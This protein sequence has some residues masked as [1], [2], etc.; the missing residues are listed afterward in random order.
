MPNL[1]RRRIASLPMLIVAVSM[2]VLIIVVATTR[3]ALQRPERR[4][5]LNRVHESMVNEVNIRKLPPFPSSATVP[6]PSPSSRKPSLSP[7]PLAPPSMHNSPEPELRYTSLSSRAVPEFAGQ[8]SPPLRNTTEASSHLQRESNNDVAWCRNVKQRF[9]VQP[10]K[11]WGRMK[12]HTRVEWGQ[13][14]CDV[15]LA[16]GRAFSCNDMWGEAYLSSWK[17]EQPCQQN[18]GF[19]LQKDHTT[20]ASTPTTSRSSIRCR[21]HLP[22]SSKACDFRDVVIDFSKARIAGNSRNFNPGFLQA[23]CPIDSR[24]SQTTIPLPPG[25]HVIKTDQ[26]GDDTHSQYCDIVEETPSLFM[27]HDLIFNLGH[28]ISDFWIVWVTLQ[29]L[30]LDESEFQL[31]NM[32]ALRGNGPAGRH[33]KLTFA[34]HPDHISP[35]LEQYKKWF[36]N[37]VRKSVDYNGKRICFKRAVFQAKP[38]PAHVWTSLEAGTNQSTER[39]SHKGRSWLLREYNH[40]N[41]KKWG[42]M[43]RRDDFASDAD[44]T[45]RQERP[46]PS[47][48][49]V[50]RKGKA[51]M[52]AFANEGEVIRAFEHIPGAGEVKHID[53]ASLQFAEQIELVHNVSCSSLAASRRPLANQVD[54]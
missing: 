10:G 27:S 48:T 24:A 4:G 15:V 23:R 26:R 5:D 46:L 29:A 41:R 43:N 17:E 3:L 11:S 12:G 40:F 1:R 47:I 51:N 8:P 25:L 53:M 38:G 42:L 52:R 20:P 34:G 9:H 54:R 7:P 30:E 6:L 14:G 19:Q 28:T 39:C 49:V 45:K 18:K 37:G 16:T 50:H 32:D 33:N 36:G 2:I 35:F 22:T 21:T 31:V 13:K 44:I